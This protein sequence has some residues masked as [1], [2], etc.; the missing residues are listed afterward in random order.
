V[1][2]NISL[3]PRRDGIWPTVSKLQVK[4]PHIASRASA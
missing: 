1:M 2:H 4:P 3:E